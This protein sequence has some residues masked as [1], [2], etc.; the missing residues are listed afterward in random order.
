MSDAE[1]GI[2]GRLTT[3]ESH[4]LWPVYDEVFH[5]KA[6]ESEWL[7][8]WSKHSNRTG[9]RLA[10][11]RIDDRLVGF[12][13]GYTGESGQWWTDM[14]KSVLDADVADEWLGGHFEL[15]SIGVVPDARGLGIGRQLLDAVTSGL[16]QDRWLLMTTADGSDPARRLYAAAGWTVIGPGLTE[17]QVIMGS[18]LAGDRRVVP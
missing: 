6:D 8:T 14:A 1:V 7:E 2:S 3:G 12:A 16:P 9:F 18:S 13:Y 5:D 17:A 10:R 11:A 15:V 4:E